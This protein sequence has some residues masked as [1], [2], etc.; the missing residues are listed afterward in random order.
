MPKIN[1]TSILPYTKTS[2][3]ANK[4]VESL[5]TLAALTP[6]TPKPA[7][8]VIPLFDCL[9]AASVYRAHLNNVNSTNSAHLNSLKTAWEDRKTP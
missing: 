9:S 3:P 2:L 7:H 6:H 4:L 8:S 5:N 1:P